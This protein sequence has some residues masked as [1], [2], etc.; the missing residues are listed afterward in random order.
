MNAY[1]TR[2]IEGIAGRSDHRREQEEAQWAET[3]AVAI[4]ICIL[5]LGALLTVTGVL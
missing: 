2:N 1:L 4:A 3:R 5:A